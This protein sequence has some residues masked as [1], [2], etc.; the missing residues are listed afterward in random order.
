M[1][2]K[3]VLLAEDDLDDQ[4]FFY[5]FL[6]HRVDIFIMDPVENGVELFCFLENSKENGGL[7]D[8]IILDQNMPKKN[9]L[10]TLQLLKATEL[11]RHIPV[12]IY[13]TYTDEQLKRNS[14]QLGASAVVTKPTSKEEYN[15]MMDIFLRNISMSVKI[16]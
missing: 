12:M 6:Q 2:R 16:V 1:A 7:P 10:Q 11:Y 3:K 4:N 13:S 15:K 14:F 8:L 5:D 9:G